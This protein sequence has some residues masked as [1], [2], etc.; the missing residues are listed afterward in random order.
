MRGEVNTLWPSTI[1]GRDQRRKLDHPDCELV[2][3]RMDRLYNDAPLEAHERAALIF[4]YSAKLVIEDLKLRTHRVKKVDL[5]SGAA[6]SNPWNDV[7]LDPD[8][9]PVTLAVTRARKIAGYVRYLELRYFENSPLS[10]QPAAI[11]PADSSQYN[12]IVFC[13]KTGC[14]IMPGHLQNRMPCEGDIEPVTSQG[15][16]LD[17]SYPFE[18]GFTIAEYDASMERYIHARRTHFESGG[19]LD[20]WNDLENRAVLARIESERALSIKSHEPEPL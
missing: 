5:M 11:A 18:I 1:A 7:L 14:E 15:P 2:A 13:A 12:D 8:Q 17:N 20:E 6:V 4:L 3:E 10:A 9:S 16:I 19:T